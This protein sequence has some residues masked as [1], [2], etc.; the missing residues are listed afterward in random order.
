MQIDRR[1][2]WAHAQVADRAAR[3]GSLCQSG[4]RRAKAICA[5]HL[6]RVS[7]TGTCLANRSVDAIAG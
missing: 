3:R 5:S 6:G 7:A 2:L 4:E 1:H